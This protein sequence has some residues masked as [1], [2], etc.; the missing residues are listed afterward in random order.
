VTQTEL[1]QSAQSGCQEAIDTLVDNHI[2]YIRFMARRFNPKD[3]PDAEQFGVQGFLEAL[4]DFD[5]SR[6]YKLIT[7]TSF[8]IRESMRH[9]IPNPREVLLEDIFRTEQTDDENDT[10]E[11]N[12]PCPEKLPIEKKLM[13]AI[14]SLS[15]IERE[16]LKL[17]YF[18]GFTLREISEIVKLSHQ[19]CYQIEQRAIKSLK[20]ELI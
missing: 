7:Y 6:G 19:R 16:I 4:R 20:K 17:H 3:R 13:D 15:D 18:E 11:D 10:I 8:R 5:T 9:A 14:R 12:I 2:K 1:I